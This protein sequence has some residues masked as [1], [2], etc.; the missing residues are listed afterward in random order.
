MIVVQ[1]SLLSAV[2]GEMRELAR[3]YISNDG[4]SDNP[5]F[6]DYNVE[7]LRGRSAEHF[8]RRTVLKRAR[9]EHYPRTALHV[10]NLVHRALSAVGYK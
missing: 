5:N 2:T 4:A 8:A 3:A 6:G 1:V 7:I 10:W 9:V